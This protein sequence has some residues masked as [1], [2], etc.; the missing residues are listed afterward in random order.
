MFHIHMS[1]GWIPP[2]PLL[3]YK[4][5]ALK[6]R[7][8]TPELQM[9]W[10]SLFKPIYIRS[11]G[12][13]QQSKFDEIEKI[14]SIKLSIKSSFTEPNNNEDN[15]DPYTTWRLQTQQKGDM[16]TPTDTLTTYPP[17]ARA[18]LIYENKQE[19]EVNWGSHRGYSKQWWGSGINPPRPCSWI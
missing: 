18:L 8:Y 5:G 4:P 2:P 9:I 12:D 11:R 6:G 1:K 14:T 15:E 10:T 16:V 13:T 3:L 7:Q 19:P 17:Q